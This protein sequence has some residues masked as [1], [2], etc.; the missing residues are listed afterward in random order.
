VETGEVE[1]QLH[2][3]AGRL[4]FSR[5]GALSPNPNLSRTLLVEYNYNAKI[6]TKR[7]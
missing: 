4:K 3:F 2:P 1:L 7:A 5:N 6:R